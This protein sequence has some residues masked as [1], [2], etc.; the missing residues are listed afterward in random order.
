[1]YSLEF[2]KKVMSTKKKEGLTYRDTSKR[3]V[4]ALSALVRWNTR[5]EPKMTRIKPTSK[6]D[7]EALKR[8]LEEHPDA[9]QYERARTLNVSTSCIQ[10]AFKR[11]NIS[12]KK[13]LLSP[14]KGRKCSYFLPKAYKKL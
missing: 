14:E 13:N 4:V 8:D 6:I 3:F 7:M 10:H 11:L 5:I 12:Y 9:Y 2:R 1:M